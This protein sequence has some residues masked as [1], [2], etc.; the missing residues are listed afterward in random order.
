MYGYK[1]VPFLASVSG[2]VEGGAVA[3]QLQ[4]AIDEHAVADWEFYGLVSPEV[5]VRPGCLAGLF[6][7]KE[8]YTRF[9]QLVFRKA[10]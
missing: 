6:G 10:S 4:A 2:V 9:D 1:I 7:A 8:S 3:K 5:K